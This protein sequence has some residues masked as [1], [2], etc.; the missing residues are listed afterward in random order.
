MKSVLKRIESYNSLLPKDKILLKYSALH[1]S[2]FRFFRG[3]CHLFAEDFGK[4]Y[5]YNSKLK[6]WICGDAHFENFGSFKGANRLVYFDMN[7]FDEAILCAPEPEICRFLTSIVIAGRQIKMQEKAIRE[8]LEALCNNYIQTLLAEKA[9]MLEEATAKGILKKYFNRLNSRNREAFIAKHTVP[10]KNGLQLKIDESHLL[11]ISNKQKDLIF[12]SLQKL[13]RQHNHFKDVECL[14][15]AYRVAGTGSLGLE[16][17]AVLTYNHEKKKNYLL[18][19][20]Q[21]RIS[22]YQREVKLKQPQFLDEAERINRVGY[23]MQFNSPAFHSRLRINKIDF[24]VKEMQPLV[25]KISVASLGNN[26]QQFSDAAHQMMPL[27]AYAQIRSSGHLTASSADDLIR[28][29]DSGNWV[30]DM[31]HLSLAMADSNDKYYAQFR[32]QHL[33]NNT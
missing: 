2:P 9:L 17:Y 29:A 19:I 12:K 14:D 33:I 31:I 16:R 1:E 13:L 22:C 18:D 11:P 7:D 21:T 6:T 25:D 4:L 30:K 20:K 10:A 24:V 23:L 8:L 32:E 28:F 15:A 3:T 27:I 26:I 5:G